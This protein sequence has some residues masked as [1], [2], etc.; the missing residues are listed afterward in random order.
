M[1][2]FDV[3]DTKQ[4]LINMIR[5]LTDCLHHTKVYADEYLA[6]ERYIR[7]YSQHQKRD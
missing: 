5:G 2:Y 3:H 4:S 1:T 7:G 6:Y